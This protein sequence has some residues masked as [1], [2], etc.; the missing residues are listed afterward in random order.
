[1]ETCE[2]TECGEVTEAEATGT[3]RYA[4]A[5]ALIRQVWGK[6]AMGEEVAPE[7]EA[8]VAVQVV[9]TGR[10]LELAEALSCTQAARRCG[11]PDGK[12]PQIVFLRD[13]LG[14][15]PDKIGPVTGVHPDEV[16]ARLARL[17]ALGARIGGK[18]DAEP[19][20]S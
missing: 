9:L 6:L 4:P 12:D 17:R 14:W 1:V 7:L 3:C 13:C 19:T 10:Q 16:R 18:Q 20:D 5:T 8:E 11:H 2:L 15:N